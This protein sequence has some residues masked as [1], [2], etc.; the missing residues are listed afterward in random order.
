MSET[1]SAFMSL[2]D[3]RKSTYHVLWSAGPISR[4]SKVRMFKTENVTWSCSQP[5]LF[6]IIIL[7]WYRC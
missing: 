1:A 7:L 2:N 5:L 3:S 4:V 6:M